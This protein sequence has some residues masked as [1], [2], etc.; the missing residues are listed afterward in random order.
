LGKKIAISLF[1]NTLL[2]EDFGFEKHYKLSGKVHY[3]FFNGQVINVYDRFRAS[4]SLIRC[5]ID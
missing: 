5:K 4:V 1:Y 2:I 3:V